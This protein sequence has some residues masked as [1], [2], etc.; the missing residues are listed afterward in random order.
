MPITTH[1]QRHQSSSLCF[2]HNTSTTLSSFSVVN[3]LS[4]EIFVAIVRDLSPADLLN[5]TFV[6]KLY[7]EYLCS[8]NSSMTQEIWRRSRLCYYPSLSLPPPEGMDEKSYLEFARLRED[9]QLCGRVVNLVVH[10]AFRLR[11]CDRCLKTNIK[12]E[13]EI[14]DYFCTPEEKR[15]ILQGL[16]YIEIRS[17]RFYWKYQWTLAEYRYI[18]CHPRKKSLWLDQQKLSTLKIMDDA[19]SRMQSSITQNRKCLIRETKQTMIDSIIDELCEIRSLDG[20]Q[21]YRSTYLRRSPAYCRAMSN[22]SEPIN[23]DWIAIKKSMKKTYTAVTFAIEFSQRQIQIEHRIDQLWRSPIQ[24]KDPCLRYLRFCPTYKNLIFFNNDPSIPF[25][26]CQLY[27]LICQIKAEAEYYRKHPNELS[28]VARALILGLERLQ[29]FR[30]ALCCKNV[31]SKI[32]YRFIDVRDHLEGSFHCVLKFVE[33]DHV[34]INEY[35]LEI[36][37]KREYRYNR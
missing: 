29:I 36:L 31:N 4:P 17:E 19:K 12:C 23:D 3:H 34:L 7:R 26:K 22:I 14:C 24:L 18:S 21:V 32:N 13:R 16:P 37:R 8:P 28:H 25:T 10:W 15:A 2:S 20:E 5:L 6:C 30:C 33:E 35:G 1:T 11:C 9:C 27:C